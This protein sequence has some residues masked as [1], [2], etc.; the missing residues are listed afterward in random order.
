MTDTEIKEE[1]I[2]LRLVI[3]TMMEEKKVRRTNAPEWKINYNE[4]FISASELQIKSIDELIAK[5]EET[6][7][8]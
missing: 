4:G 2:I 6:E 1:L 5:I 8:K 7:K 3:N